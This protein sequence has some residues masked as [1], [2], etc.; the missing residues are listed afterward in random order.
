VG[1]LSKIIGG[2]SRR[3][4]RGPAEAGPMQD[5]GME[6]EPDTAA[7]LPP[8]PPVEAGG[9]EAHNAHLSSPPPVIDQTF[10]AD[11]V[12]RYYDDWNERYEAVFGEVFQHLKAADHDQLLGHMAEVAELGD[13][14]RVLD[15]GCG[16]CGPARHFART[17]DVSIDAVTISP[18]QA[19]RARELVERDG[20]AD[21]ITVHV[22]DFHHLDDV[23]APGSRDLVYFLEALV[24][25]HDPL[26]ALRSAFTVLGPGGRLYVKDFYRGR[27]DDPAAQRVI[28]ECV[29]ATNRICHLTIR[30]TEDVVAWVQE[31][32]FDVEV[33]QPLAVPTY[34]IED[35]HEFC[36]RYGLDV[37]AGRDFTTTFYLDN[38]E[39][40]AR[41]P[42]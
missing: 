27:S 4:D 41:K 29:E 16:V 3:A 10:P 9:P 23:V 18:K 33:C 6:S 39:I 14:D 8:P 37:A 31:A 34:S 7:G 28:D 13:G 2:A 12:A 17:H 40:R 21:R 15:A 19:E 38:L 32:G 36:R 1:F 5:P 42:R 20:F 11:D 35:G 26:T 25:A 24:H 22:G 30:N